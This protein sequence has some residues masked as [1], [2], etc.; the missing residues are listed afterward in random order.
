VQQLLDKGEFIHLDVKPF[1]VNQVRVSHVDRERGPN[2]THVMGTVQSITVHDDGAT[3]FVVTNGGW[4]RV[5]DNDADEL[6]TLDKGGLG[7]GLINA[8]Q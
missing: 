3:Y 1:G 6:L 7:W 8:P 2:R 4:A 5:M